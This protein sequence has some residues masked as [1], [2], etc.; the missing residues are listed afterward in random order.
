[1]Y[2][3]GDEVACTVVWHGTII[4]ITHGGAIWQMKVNDDGFMCRQ[5]LTAEL[6]DA[7]SR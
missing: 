6:S 1:M 7:P 3:A 4:A 5:K 2:L